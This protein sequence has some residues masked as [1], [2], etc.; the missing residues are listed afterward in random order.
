[1][2]SFLL[3]IYSSK[4]PPGT[5]VPSVPQPRTCAMRTPCYVHTRVSAHTPIPPLSVSAELLRH[6]QPLEPHQGL[7]PPT[8]PP[9]K[10]PIF[11]LTQNTYELFHTRWGSAEAFKFAELEKSDGKDLMPKNAGPFPAVVSQEL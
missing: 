3:S 6:V 10:T 11:T 5:D 8:A 7:S 2:I 9:A 1:M 4:Q